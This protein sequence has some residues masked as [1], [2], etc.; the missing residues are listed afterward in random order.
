MNWESGPSLRSGQGEPCLKVEGWLDGDLE[1]ADRLQAISNPTQTHR[2]VATRGR[3]P[4]AE[5]RCE[6][7]VKTC[8]EQGHKAGAGDHL[9]LLSLESG[10]QGQLGIH[11]F[12]SQV[13]KKL[14]NKE[15][16][17]YENHIKK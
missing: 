14:R 15:W 2:S 11:L 6:C 16:A 9:H 8:P 17:S 3:S 13:A 1:A 4:P 12:P 10:E 5:P 7:L